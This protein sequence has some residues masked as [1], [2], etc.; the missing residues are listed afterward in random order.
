MKA[1]APVNI[2]WVKYMGKELNQNGARPTNSSFSMTLSEYGTET[3][4]IRLQP[5]GSL[6]FEFCEQGYLPPPNGQAKAFRFLQDFT[7]FMHLLQKWGF[8]SIAPSGRY[9]IET[10][11]SVPA[12]TGIA[13]S[14]SGFAALTLAWIPHLMS[15]QEFAIFRSLFASDSGLRGDL[16]RVSAR[17]SGSACRSFHGPFVE[18]RSDGEVIPFSDVAGGWIDLILM[19]E[20]GPKS[21]SSSEAHT[22]VRSSP[23]FSGRADRAHERLLRV[24][25]ALALGRWDWISS[26][27]LEEALDMHE[28][29]HTS[30][31]PFRYFNRESEAWRDRVLSGKGLPSRHAALTFDAGANAHL[32]VPEAESEIWVSWLRS[33]FP[34]LVFLRSS[35]GKGA[36]YR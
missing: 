21:V 13:T 2:A 10:R 6:E 7:P 30:V 27:V 4:I 22:R 8:R 3:Q 28:L 29:F 33:E 14:A 9:R 16:A 35:A 25:E 24:K 17:G 18:W 26:S 12:G 32:F 11:N 20:E 31:P 23:L 1:F 34:G 5:S 36:E 15:A 19:L